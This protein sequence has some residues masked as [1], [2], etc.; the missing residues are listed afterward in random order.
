[1]I[2]DALLTLAAI[3]GTVLFAVVLSAIAEWAILKWGTPG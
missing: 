3:A 2:H 1:M